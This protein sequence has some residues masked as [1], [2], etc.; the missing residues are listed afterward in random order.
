[1]IVKFAADDLQIMWFLSKFNPHL[2]RCLGN[3]FS[4][5]CIQSI[6]LVNDGRGF[7]QYAESVND[8]KL[9]MKNCEK[10]NESPNSGLPAFVRW[11]RQF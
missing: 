8:R 3:C 4:Q 5:F 2:I 11:R 9:K 1:M 10:L 6:L 7:F